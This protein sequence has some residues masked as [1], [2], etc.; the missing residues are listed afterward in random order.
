METGGADD[1]ETGSVMEE[2]LVLIPASSWTSWTKR[3][4]TIIDVLRMCCLITSPRRIC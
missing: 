2:G 1:S 4:T 3:A